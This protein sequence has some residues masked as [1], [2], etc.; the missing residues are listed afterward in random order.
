MYLSEK[1]LSWEESITISNALTTG[2]LIELNA[3]DSVMLFLNTQAELAYL[4]SFLAVN[5]LISKVGENIVTEII[6]DLG[7]SSSLDA[8]FQRRLGYSF[9]EFEIEYYDD[10]KNRYRWVSWLQF[11][12]LFWVLLILIVFMVFLLK[13]IRNRRIIRE[14]EKEDY[15]NLED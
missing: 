3:V 12:N 9:F 10:L 14:W 15:F 11:E 8:V 6:K 5:Y 7:Y 2:N 1:E 4:Q 13:K